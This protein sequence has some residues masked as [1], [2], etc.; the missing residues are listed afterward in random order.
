MLRI[1]FAMRTTKVTIVSDKRV[2]TLPV[3]DKKK[4]Y[5]IVVKK[6][7]KVICNGVTNSAQRPTLFKRQPCSYLTKSF[8]HRITRC[9]GRAR[10]QLESSVSGAF[11][12]DRI[13]R[14]IPPATLARYASQDTK[15]TPL[16]AARMIARARHTSRHADATRPARSARCASTTDANAKGTSRARN[17]IGAA[18]RHTDYAL[19]TLMDA[20]SVTVA[21]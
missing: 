11:Y 13:A 8:R 17:A 4:R 2:I 5:R 3:T 7:K 16:E 18:R 6:E 10:G 19:R 12:V 20:S 21:G 15:E 14:I 1:S 9:K